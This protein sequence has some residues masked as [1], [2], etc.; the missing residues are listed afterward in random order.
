MLITYITVLKNK[1]IKILINTIKKKLKN[2]FKQTA[3]SIFKIIY[4]EIKGISNS[5]NDSRV[6]VD[7]VKLFDDNEYK[8]FSIQKGRIYTDTIN[9]T[10]IIIDKNLVDGASFQIRGVKNSK[11]INNIVFTKGTPKIKKKLKGSIFSLL[12]GGAGNANYWHWL[13]DVLPRIKILTEKE[14]LENIDYFLFPDVNQKFQKETL[15]ILNIEK[16]KR[17]SSKNYRHIQADKVFVVDHPYVIKNDPSTEIQNIPRWIVEW[18]KKSFLNNI[19]F[20]KKMLPRKFYIDRKDAKSNHSHLRK[21]TNEKQIKEILIKN[22]FSNIVLSD[23][24]FYDQVN[25]FNNATHIVGLHGAGF[26]NLVFSK[27]NTLVLE[28]KSKFSGPVC[29]N[30][31]K[32]NNLNYSDI[33]VVPTEH[34]GRNQQGHIEIPLDLLREKIV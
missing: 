33:S 20:E 24:N 11:A 34:V 21:I 7:K 25:L 26:A 31:A 14:N 27:P 32:H 8:I 17:L 13:F 18:L 2:L 4:G 22:G 6:G 10:A 9:D 28:L 1:Y 23:L 12:T 3:Y 5:N 30:L 29:G 19:N 16:S 15:D